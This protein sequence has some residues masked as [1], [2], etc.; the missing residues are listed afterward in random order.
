MSFDAQEHTV[1]N[2]AK[3][4]S[5]FEQSTDENISITCTINASEKS[6]PNIVETQ[7]KDRASEGSVNHDQGSNQMDISLLH[8]EISSLKYM[9][10]E[11]HTENKMAQ[12][13]TEQ[14]LDILQNENEE[15]K[16]NV[17]KLCCLTNDV[18]ETIHENKEI[19]NELN[20]SKKLFQKIDHLSEQFSEIKVLIH[21]HSNSSPENACTAN[22]D[23]NATTIKLGSKGNDF[24]NTSQLHVKDH[25]VHKSMEKENSNQ[26][27]EEKIESDKTAIDF[28]KLSSTRK[29]N[30]P[31][32]TSIA[33]SSFENDTENVDPT[34]FAKRKHLRQNTVDTYVKKNSI[35]V[36]HTCKNLLIGDSNLK[37]CH[38]KETRQ[39]RENGGTHI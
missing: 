1:S 32:N 29:P 24:E 22:F 3:P 39:N 16:H 19:I 30:S 4:N 14:K 6:P 13:N 2:T 17:S 7:S 23:F 26:I 38:K 15:L 37:K 33:W 20:K 27:M 28:E 31:S 12:R 36:P 18:I 35:F 21:S 11:I 9:L 10:E 8:S 25:N 34:L 5:D